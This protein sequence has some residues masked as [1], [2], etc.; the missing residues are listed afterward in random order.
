MGMSG[1]QISRMID[2]VDCGFS[3]AQAAVEVDCNDCEGVLFVGV[4]GTTAVR[5]WSMALKYAVS[6][7][8]S[9]INCATTY[10]HASTA[11][12][13]NVLVTDVHKP[14]GRYLGA[15]LSSSS[16]TPS[17]LLAFKYGVRKS[18]GD[19]SVT[20]GANTVPIATGGIKRVVSP[21]SS[22]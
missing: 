12:N 5:L 22:T 2:L 17:R 1:Q 13:N 16:A 10:T 18:I 7:T 20:G 9:F 14:A 3:T 19:F 11:A 4:P 21:T 15:T 8:A 6:S